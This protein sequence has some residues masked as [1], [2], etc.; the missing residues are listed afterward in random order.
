[1][2]LETKILLTICLALTAIIVYL[3]YLMVNTPFTSSN[4]RTAYFHGCNF[5][6]SIISEESIDRCEQ[7]ADIYKGAIE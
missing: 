3:T 2:N 4:M 1:M 5:G 6:T 7:I